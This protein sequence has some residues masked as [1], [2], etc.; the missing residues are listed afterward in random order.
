M[1]GA[2][3]LE[4]GGTGKRRQGES[5][6]SEGNR[7]AQGQLKDTGGIELKA[8]AA[9]SVRSSFDSFAACI[10]P[11]QSATSCN[12]SSLTLTHPHQPASGV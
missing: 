8:S 1:V 9:A 7:A 12:C 6:T 4:S 10:L 3:V 2:S 11:S 5:W